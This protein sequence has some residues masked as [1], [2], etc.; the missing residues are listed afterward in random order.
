MRRSGRESGG[1]AFLKLAMA[2][3]PI[4]QILRPAKLEC[5]VLKERL[6][7]YA[8]FGADRLFDSAAGLNDG[9]E[10]VPLRRSDYEPER[11]SEFL[12]ISFQCFDGL[13]EHDRMVDLR[14]VR[15]VEQGDA[16]LLR[17]LDECLEFGRTR[18]M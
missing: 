10:P 1:A 11:R 13:F 8:L 14:I 15:G 16:T 4:Q 5:A 9:I 18:C 7:Q 3:G 6:H 12:G 17:V 2:S